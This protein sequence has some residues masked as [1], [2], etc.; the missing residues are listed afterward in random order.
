MAQGLKLSKQGKGFSWLLGARDL[1]FGCV[2][3]LQTAV[4]QKSLKV[5]QKSEE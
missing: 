5:S 2:D 1:N 4:L 3:Q